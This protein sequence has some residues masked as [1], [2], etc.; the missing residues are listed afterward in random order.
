MH[1]LKEKIFTKYR[2]MNIGKGKNEYCACCKSN[3][4]LVGP[5]SIFHIGKNFGEDPYKIVFVGKNSWYPKKKFNEDKR[6]RDFL[7]MQQ[8]LEKMFFKEIII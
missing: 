6:K 4:K 8:I 5:I 1:R 7:L 2:K 3:K